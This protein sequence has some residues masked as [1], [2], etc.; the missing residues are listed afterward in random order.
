MTFDV[1]TVPPELERAWIRALRWH[2]EFFNYAY[3]RRA[4][5]KP[6]FQIGRSSERLGEWAGRTRTITIAARHILQHTWEC[7]LD[8]LRHEMAHQYAEEVLRA[9]ERPHGNAWEEACRLLRVAP[10]ARA[11]PSELENLAA[12][13]A[14]RDRMLQ[15]V[16]ELLALA[17]SPNEHEAESA[18]R[19]AHKYLL[20][21]N[22]DVRELGPA[23]RYETR[24]LG[25]CQTRFQEYEY[26]LAGILQDHFF[27]EV[28]FTWSYLAQEDRRGRILQISG[29]PENLDI[30]EYVHEYVLGLADPLWRAHKKSLGPRAG[31]RLQYLAGLLRG[32]QEKLDAQKQQLSTEQGLV[33]LGDSAL[34]A[35]FRH[36]HPRVRSSGVYGVE[37]GEGYAAGMRD[38]REITLKKGVRGGGGSAG[39][40]LVRPER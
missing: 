33:W 39:R 20:K 1:F 12:S 19:M 28:I 25:K 31:T 36:V 23:T 3:V 18:M 7:V 15:R 9:R 16:K 22:L 17:T 13:K 21:Y 34:K 30:A 37:R 10:A 32:F 11:S 29:T 38:G 5:R 27:V 24:A 8:T 35:Y 26:V 40:L 14:E 6:I 2:Y 4:L